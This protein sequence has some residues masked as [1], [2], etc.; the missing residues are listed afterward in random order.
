MAADLERLK[1]RLRAIP[2]AVKEDVQRTL[3]KQA[4]DLA[5]SMR[6][7]APVD[8]GALRDSIT[9]TPGGQSTPPYSQPGG[10]KVVPENA[11]AVTVG[12][13]EVRYPHLQEFGTAKAPAQPYFWPAYRLHKTRIKRAIA[14]SIGRAVRK[15]WTS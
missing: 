3:L 8:T 6:N 2:A 11:V 4:N 13:A 7:L 9:V 15:H 12:N 5:D 14:R 1:R 10:S